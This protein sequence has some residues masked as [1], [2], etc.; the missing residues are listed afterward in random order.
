MAAGCARV[1]VRHRHG[2]KR[3]LTI[4]ACAALW[5]GVAAGRGA[6]DG[7]WR[8]STPQVRKEVVAVVEAQLAAFRAGAGAKAYG[9]AAAPLRAQTPLRAFLAI[10]QNNY[11]EIWANTR[12]EFGLVRDDG[13]QATVL[14]HV[15]SKESDASYDYGL[16]KEP[17][18]W[19]IG[20]VLRRNPA[21]A[22]KV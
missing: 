7:E 22:D 4:A 11:P 1:A 9:F 15:F 13:T 16:F 2:E 18:G 8:A 3:W 20:R 19:R 5:L 21:R 17:A 6:E 14:V 12:V 10:V